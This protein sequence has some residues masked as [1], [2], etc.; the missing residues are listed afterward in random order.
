[1]QVSVEA[2]EGLQR[3]LTITVPAEQ[4]DSEV[5]KRLRQL[6]KTR[7]IDGFRPGKAPISV[8][9]KMYGP[10]VRQDVAGELMQRQYVEAIVSEKLNPAGAPSLTVED[11]KA[12]QDLKFTATIE[13]Y[14]EFEV[15]G[16]DAIEIEK[17][18]VDVKEEDIDQM[19]DTLR[20]QH[21]TWEEVERKAA[22][23]DRVNIDFEGKVDG[24]AFDG[25]KAEGFDLQIGSGRMIPG[26]EE[27]VVGLAAGEEGVVNVTFPED[28]Q[29]E[30]LKG[31]AAEFSVK[32]NKVEQ[33]K[34]PELNEEFVKQFAVDSGK[35]EDLRAE[36][37]KNMNRELKQNLKSAVKEQVVNGLLAQN[38]INVPSALV[39]QEIEQLRKQ[40]VQRFGNNQ[41]NMPE[42]PRE[43]FEEQAVRRVKVG[44]VLGE[45][46]KSEKIEADEER[47]N[48]LIQDM[49]SAYEDADEVV[50]YYKEN[51]E[52]LEQMRNLAVEDQAVDFV[53]SKAKITEVEKSFK[54][55][56]QP[57]G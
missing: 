9:K 20:K 7:R 47:V 22:D 18:T 6:A 51:K 52:L 35:V 49:A 4:V 50:S 40:A 53:L 15:Q 27:G 5:T 24:E 42:L 29:A 8:I 13:V 1:M 38:D 31:K 23:G 46:I 30:N 36:V 26:F 3:R 21:A 41:P 48:N 28:Y 34:L 25:G 39:D 54:D 56:M 45:L 37:E 10:A 33:Q 14:P 19:L 2:T 44:L 17:A 12:G 57:Q 11:D 55:I 32:V 16:L 43:L